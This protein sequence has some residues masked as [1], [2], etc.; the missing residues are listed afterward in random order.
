MTRRWDDMSKSRPPSYTLAG[1]CFLF[2]VLVGIIAAVICLLGPKPAKAS[3]CS[4]MRAY[5][6]ASAND[7]ARRDTMGNHDYFHAHPHYGGE[8]IGYGYKSEAA[9]VAAW[10]RSPHHAEN[11]RLHYPC[12][13]TAVARSSSG[14]LYYAMEIGD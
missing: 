5:A 2:I 6:Y 11:M 1:R 10:W 9:M 3:D 12:K 8:N 14:K 13:V 7:M 4:A